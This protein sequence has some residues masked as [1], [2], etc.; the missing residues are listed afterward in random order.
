M[1][2]Q[3]REHKHYGKMLFADNGILE[4]GIPL[5]FGIR[6]GHF[7]FLGGENI[8]FEQP[9]DM[10]QFS[11][12]DGWR[13]HC[14]HRLWIAPET[15]DDYYPDNDPIEYAV[16]GDALILTQREDPRLHVQKTFV[17]RFDK[18]RLCVTHRIKNLADETLH[19]SLW[20]IS[21][22]AA[23]GVEYIDLPTRTGEFSHWTRISA[24]D[25]TD[26]GDSRASYSKEQI[27]IRQAVADSPYK[28]GVGHP[29]SPVRYEK[30]DIVFKKHF[31]IQRDMLYPDANVSFETYVSSHMLEMESL[32]PLVS[33]E[34]NEEAEHTEIWELLRK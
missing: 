29:L 14:G 17:I 26:L 32:S 11:T 8:M 5:E 10:T 9:N 30:G 33:L 22:L 6:I 15:T 18:D 2:I 24:W 19:C 20:P 21:T 4:I 27:R 28:I 34:K 1:N 7:S 3:I 23:G 12:A 13:I 25:Y 31:D 16:E